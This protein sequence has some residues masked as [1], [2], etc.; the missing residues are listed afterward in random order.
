MTPEGT[1]LYIGAFGVLAE[2]SNPGTSSAKWT[3]YLSVGNA[4]VGM[5]TLQVTSSTLST[6]YFLTDHLGS[7]S[8][9]TD[10]NGLVVQ[11]LSYDAWGKRR[12]PDGT[13]DTT[14]SITSPTTRLRSAPRAIRMPISFLRRTTIYAITP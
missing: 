3:E 14:G 12:N 7:V 4:K 11:R 6:R 8:V 1:T 13:D 5:R 10:E 9:I 2:V